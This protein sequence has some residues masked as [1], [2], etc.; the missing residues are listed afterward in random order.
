MI[1]HAARLVIFRY[2]WKEKGWICICF[3]HFLA[4]PRVNC[5]L[6]TF[7]I[8]N[9]KRKETKKLE[10]ATDQPNLIS[11]TVKKQHSFKLCHWA[12]YSTT[13]KEKKSLDNKHPKHKQNIKTVNQLPSSP[14]EWQL[15]PLGLDNWWW[16]VK[17]RR[18]FSMILSS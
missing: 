15:N 17:R 3:F 1:Y 11:T 13:T 7:D 4:S 8:S 18:T 12:Q 10:S 9:W 14:A 16:K 5:L 6:M 2:S